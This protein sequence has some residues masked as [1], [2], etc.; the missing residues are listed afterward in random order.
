[1]IRALTAL[2]RR[3]RP[4]GGAA[5]PTPLPQPVEGSAA[6][7]LES[8][9]RI[10]TATRLR[11]NRWCSGSPR[12]TREALAEEARHAALHLCEFADGIEAADLT[13]ADIDDLLGG[14]S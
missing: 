1:M 12:I 14:A 10:T 11:F 13:D 8:A 4:Q 2:F 9:H 5:A 6:G 7:H 3:P